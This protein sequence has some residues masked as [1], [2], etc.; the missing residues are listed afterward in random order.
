MRVLIL[1]G[2]GVFGG[3]LA[4]LLAEDARLTL[5]IAGRSRERAEAFCTGLVCSAKVEP[6][7]FDRAGYALATRWRSCATTR[8]TSS[9]M[10]RDRSR[11]M[12]RIPM[13]W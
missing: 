12:A 8:R 9:S 7:R 6:L 5:L 1:G 10:P 13:R 2:Y 11:S 3:R 4:R